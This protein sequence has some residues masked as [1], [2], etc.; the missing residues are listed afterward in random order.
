MVK[1]PSSLIEPSS[2]VDS[3][4]RAK[5]FVDYTAEG[6]VASIGKTT[7]LNAG[8][9]VGDHIRVKQ[10]NSTNMTQL[11]IQSI[12]DDGTVTVEQTD[13][14]GKP[15]TD[16]EGNLDTFTVEMDEFFHTYMASQ[17]K[18]YVS[19][20]STKKSIDYFNDDAH[21]AAAMVA[22]HCSAAFALLHCFHASIKFT[23]AMVLSPLTASPE[24]VS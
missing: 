17:E 6:G 4:D 5:N 16:E 10:D 19:E 3:G 15:K 21:R 8:F 12:A 18:I 14:E 20:S 13:E 23:A 1:A 2:I 9:H 7:V 22:L 24:K 11:K